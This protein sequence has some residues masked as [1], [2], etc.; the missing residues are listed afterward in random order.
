MRLNKSEF[1]E[2]PIYSEKIWNETGIEIHD[3][4]EYLFEAS[5][6]WKDLRKK[7]DADGYS[8]LYMSLFNK[9][10]RS[11]NNKWFALIGSLNMTDSF[12]IGTCIQISFQKA[13]ILFCFAN[14]IHSFYWNNSGY[15]ILRITRVK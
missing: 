2:V 7:T 15:V 5:G 6:E 3:G 13:G 1:K 14:D 11:K 10:K 12:L 9:F 4:D 8:N